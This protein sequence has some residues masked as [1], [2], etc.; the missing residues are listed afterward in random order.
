[1]M[2]R[3]FIGLACVVVVLGSA[4]MAIAGPLGNAAKAGD[5]AEIERL[6]DEG[7]D[8]N[9]SGL[10]TPLFYAIQYKHTDAAH[11]LIERGA[12]VNKAS[13]WGTPLNEAAKQGNAEIVGLLLEQG[14]DHTV[15]AAEGLTPLHS[16]AEGGSVEA[17][18][19]LLDHGA[20]IN[21]LTTFEEPPI[22][23]ARLKGHEAVAQLLIENGWAPPE[24]TPVS[25]LL[26]S[27]DLDKGE[28]TAKGCAGGCHKLEKGKNS[29]A[30]SLWNVVGRPKASISNYVYSPTFAS[31]EGAWTFE[32][33]NAYLAHPSQVIPGTMMGAFRGIPDIQ[34]R[35]NL[36]AY[37]R[38]LS[39][40]PV[41]LP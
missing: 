33:L 6:L 22:H 12:D 23:F 25:D 27:A 31:L 3:V 21:A 20:D 4:S 38:T 36:I 24:V 2:T 7:A 14:A 34:E 18:Q 29:F 1:M 35:A 39:D 8:V 40:N 26:A 17:V 16:A 41:P 5:I 10:A 30:P 19:H 9:E 13:T 15:T 37:L 28:I 32:E 11:L